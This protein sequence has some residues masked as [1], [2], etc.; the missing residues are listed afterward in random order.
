M[1]IRQLLKGCI[2]KEQKI[3]LCN[4][5]KIC[6]IRGRCSILRVS[7][8][9]LKLA[10]IGFWFFSLD[11]SVGEALPL[12]IGK[13]IIAVEVDKEKVETG[14]IFTYEVTV[15]GDLELSAQLKLPEFKNLR[16]VSQNQ[17]RNYSIKGGVAK[18]TI[19]FTYHIFAPK[20]GVFTI[21]PVIL[22]TGENKYQSRSI[23]IKA[24]GKPLEEKKKILPYIEKGTIL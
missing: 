22:E 15:Q 23:T 1:K 10:L 8:R 21:K 17:S 4:L 6:V 3:N 11:F 5:L 9:P 19:N 13:K 2:T 16:V 24:S 20:P 12:G 7:Q 14:E 18:T